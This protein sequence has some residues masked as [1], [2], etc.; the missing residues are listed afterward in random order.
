MKI[1]IVDREIWV[2][3]DLHLFHTNIIKYCKRPFSSMEEM[4]KT[5]INNWIE[6]ISDNDIVFFLGDFVLNVEDKN[7]SSKLIYDFLPG[8]K[9]FIRGNHDKDVTTIPYI[10][11][12]VILTYDNK[13]F[14]LT[15]YPRK[16]FNTDYLLYGHVHNNTVLHIENSF[17]VSADVIGFKP[18]NIKKIIEI[19]DNTNE[20]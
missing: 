3:A 7:L 1:E 9:Y 4:N 20:I 14:T 12:D 17:N 16:S 10:D 19:L 13:T 6:T 5:I 2:I 18:I 15:H 8:E 11:E